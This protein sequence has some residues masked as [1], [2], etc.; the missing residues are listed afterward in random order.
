MLIS[1]ERP[2]LHLSEQAAS[3]CKVLRDIQQMFA[4][5][6]YSL[7][8]RS[9]PG[10]YGALNS[11]RGTNGWRCSTDVSGQYKGAS[12]LITG[13]ISSHLSITPPIAAPEANERAKFE[14]Q[15]ALHL[16]EE[17]FMPA[18][19]LLKYTI[20]L[21]Y[22]LSLLSVLSAS[23]I[24]YAAKLC[25]WLPTLEQ[26]S[27][28]VS[29]QLVLGTLLVCLGTALRVA[30]YRR[31]GRNFTFELA[32]RQGHTLVTDGPYALV[33][34]PSY[35]GS[36]LNIAGLIIGHLGPGGLAADLG[37]WRTPLGIAVVTAQCMLLTYIMGTLWL[38]LQRE[39]DALQEAFGD[40]WRSWAVR[41]PCRILPHV[42]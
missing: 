40:E 21:V 33:R 27:V 1:L 31:L 19:V 34:H 30:C 20:N 36:V 13:Y 12:L 14:S 9:R 5:G 3:W 15:K 16:L 8:E 2:L 6:S 39:D 7:H 29:P 37:L 22:A 18:A 32:I 25:D 42:Y 4:T 23:G 10:Q 26:R 28:K 11:R 41:T 38:R 17:W 24:A 35:L